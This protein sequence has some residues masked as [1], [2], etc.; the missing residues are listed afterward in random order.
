MRK[1]LVL[2]VVFFSILLQAEIDE[3]KSDVYFANGINTKQD[4]AEKGAYTLRDETEVDYPKAFK[5]IVDWKV[6]YNKTKGFQQDIYESSIQALFVKLDDKDHWSQ[7]AGAVVWVVDTVMGL[8]GV[9]D[10]VKG[11]IYFAGKKIVKE[12]LKDLLL[13]EAKRTFAKK[14]LAL[15]KEE[16]LFLSDVLFDE[17]LDNL[18]SGPLDSTLDDINKDVETQ[19]VAYMES[20][21]KGHGVI[22][23]AHSQ[24]NFFTNFVV[25]NTIPTWAK[26]YFNVIGIATP[27]SS[28][29]NGGS[30]LT[31][32]N[33]VIQVVPEH[34]GANVSNPK[35][36]YIENDVGEQIETKVSIEAHS[37]LSSYMATDVTRGAILGF[38]DDSVSVHKKAPSQWE[39]SVDIGCTCKDKAI[40]VKHKYDS[41]LD[42]LMQE[43]YVL[44]FDE[45]GKL[46]ATGFDYVKGSAE[47]ESVLNDFSSE[48]CR[49]LLDIEEKPTNQVISGPLV[50]SQPKSGVVEVFLSWDKPA[51]DLD[52]EVKWDAGSVDI[53]DSGCPKE[54]FYVH[55]EGKI[56]P[57]RY[58]INVAITQYYIDYFSGISNIHATD[59]SV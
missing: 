8:P 2:F 50:A 41:T 35:S 49:T 38:I 36:Y 51:I 45:E 54:H 4:D 52:L 14:G 37:F 53:K 24:G 30:H 27:T 10:L 21:K 39:K 34:L 6:S 26:Q 20:V 19:Y 9:K 22:I 11:A 57:G 5:S 7:K 12:E 55:N 15:T 31:F 25:E 48:V 40:F 47:G 58:S 16:I 33:D 56:F 28:I 32:D 1:V 3:R 23:V 46:Y 42:A 17:L 18:L 59:L 29:V 43:L 13:D 44:P